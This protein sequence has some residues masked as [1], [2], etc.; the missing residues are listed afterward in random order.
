MFILILGF[1]ML[2]QSSIVTPESV[3]TVILSTLGTYVGTE[4]FKTSSSLANTLI[5]FGLSAV[6]AVIALFVADLISGTEISVARI[7]TYAAQAFVLANFAY[8]S[9]Q[10]ASSRE[11]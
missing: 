4:L 9:I 6:I 3:V 10:A 1:L 5:A 11:K 8:R 2:F 7:S